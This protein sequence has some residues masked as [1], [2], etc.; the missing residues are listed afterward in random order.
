MVGW[1]KL[2]LSI[3]LLKVGICYGL[4]GLQWMLDREL[5]GDAVGRGHLHLHPAW[6]QVVNAANQIIY[7]N[8]LER[9]VSLD[10]VT[11]PVG[12]TCGGSP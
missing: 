3:T 7:V 6:L 5:K 4:Q 8:S 11:A 2:P 12:G 9:L 10:F 1:A